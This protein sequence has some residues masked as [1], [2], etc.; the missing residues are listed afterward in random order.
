MLHPRNPLEVYGVI[1]LAQEATGKGQEYRMKRFAAAGYGGHKHPVASADKSTFAR[2]QT[3]V[4][5]GFADFEFAG[6]E[7]HQHMVAEPVQ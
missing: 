4:R 5:A 6:I 7:V 2:L 1:K 3:L